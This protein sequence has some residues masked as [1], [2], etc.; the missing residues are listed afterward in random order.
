MNVTDIELLAGDEQILSVNLDSP[1]NHDRYIV[2][3]IYGLD[4]DELFAKFYAF[5]NVTQDPYF[6]LG[7]KKREIVMRLVLS[8]NWD[9]SED[10]SVIRSDLYKAI[11]HSRNGL[12]KVC[13]RSGTTLVA[14]AEGYIRKFEV[15]HMNKDP[16]LQITI[17]CDDPFFY[18]TTTQ[19]FTTEDFDTSGYISLPDQ[20]TTAPHGLEMSFYVDS[21]CPSLSIEDG[22]ATDWY[23]RLEYAGGFL[24]GD[25]IYINT[26]DKEREVTL[27]R[28]VDQ[29][30]LMSSVHPDSVWPMIFPG[31]NEFY[32]PQ[33]DDGDVIISSISYVAKFWGV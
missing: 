9:L 19:E 15:P 27:T 23:F 30:G 33:V 13:L 26:T 16:E 7:M 5:G 28:G 17:E 25:S 31:D 11:A 1:G 32:I 22:L 3:A 14:Q 18:G 8:P 4:A 6:K 29:I 20:F 21:A 10:Y 12:V 2:K 24:A